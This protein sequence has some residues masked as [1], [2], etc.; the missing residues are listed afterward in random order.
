MECY[1]IHFGDPAYLPDWSMVCGSLE[2]T[3]EAVD[4][5]ADTETEFCFQRITCEEL[6]DLNECDI[7]GLSKLDAI[8]KLNAEVYSC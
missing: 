4:A 7:S 8:D 6:A 5:Q 1:I 3:R 2:E